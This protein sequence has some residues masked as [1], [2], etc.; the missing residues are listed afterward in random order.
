[1][2]TDNG[3]RLWPNG[4][5]FVGGWD[6]FGIPVIL[7]FKTQHSIVVM[8]EPCVAGQLIDKCRQQLLGMRSMWCTYVRIISL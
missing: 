5:N 4:A 6:R 1:M 8:V 2:V 7:N 3:Y